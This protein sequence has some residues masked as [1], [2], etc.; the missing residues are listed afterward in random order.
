M[1]IFVLHYSALIPRKKNILMQFKKNN[2]TDYEFIESYDALYLSQRDTSIFN[3]A[4]MKTSMMSLM[5]KHFYAYRQIA[6]LYDYAL[7][8]EDDVTFKR[9]NVSNM[10]S[11]SFKY[12]IPENCRDFLLYKII[13]RVF[14]CIYV[15]TLEYYCL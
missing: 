8:F 10:K 9:C 6:S 7:I 1:K 14:Y 15:S 13:S 3:L 5:L 11:I 4:N 2:I 12:K